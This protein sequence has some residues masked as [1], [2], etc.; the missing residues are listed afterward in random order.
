MRKILVRKLGVGSV[1]KFVGTAN[2]I[3]ALIWGVLL[4]FAGIVTTVEQADWTVAE[5]LLGTVWSV[6]GG[7]VLVPAL[8]FVSGWLYGAVVALVA[9]LFLHTSRGIELDVEDTK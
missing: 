2:A 8:G 3:L 7:L 5:K 1:A 9:N 4:M 6:L